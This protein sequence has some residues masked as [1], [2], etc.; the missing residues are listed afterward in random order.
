VLSASDSVD[1]LGSE[2]ATTFSRHQPGRAAVSCSGAEP[3][4]FVGRRPEPQNQV[5]DRAAPL[6][7]P[8]L[9]REPTAPHDHRVVAILDDVERRERVELRMEGESWLIV[10]DPAT[11]RVAVRALA[12]RGD[13]VIVRADDCD[14][15]IVH[16]TLSML[17]SDSAR[18]LVIDGVDDIVTH[19]LCDASGRHAWS[20]LERFVSIE[21]PTAVAVTCS[22]ESSVP[23]I[24]RD[25][26][27]RV[28]RMVDRDGGFE[29]TLD[30]RTVF[31]RFVVPV[32]PRPPLR[33]TRFPT[34][35]E[36]ADTF[37][38]FVDDERPVSPPA[39]EPW[40]VSIVGESGSGRTTAMRALTAL[41]HRE[42]SDGVRRLVAIDDDVV[43][44]SLDLDDDALDVIAVIDPVRAR[45]AWDHWS[46]ALRRHRTG[47]LLADAV[48]E[49]PDVLGV[50]PPH[51]PHATT[52]GRGEW[53]VRGRAMGTVQ[54]AV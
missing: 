34:R 28:L 9:P 6:W 42:R 44:E 31:G 52:A 24:L 43:V 33:A 4:V 40:R 48:L 53:V 39:R 41:W 54:V 30:G 1:L 45:D 7:L 8:P 47:L 22:R 21:N 32:N 11:R 10:G 19:Q 27:T 12:E 51:R 49:F 38:V 14:A 3:V 50:A 5:R 2:V 23:T 20:R 17:R 18:N 25:R 37:A 13:G 46:H 16:R 35:Y 36:R 29:T 15:E 26:C